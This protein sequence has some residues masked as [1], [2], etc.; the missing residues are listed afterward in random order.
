MNDKCAERAFHSEVAC[1]GRLESRAPLDVRLHQHKAAAPE[2]V[3]ARR[4][5]AGRGKLSNVRAQVR[6]L[7]HAVV[8]M[9]KAGEGSERPVQRFNQRTRVKA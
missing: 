8:R 3:R 5:R 9:G 7:A 6:T 2:S 1:L 4:K